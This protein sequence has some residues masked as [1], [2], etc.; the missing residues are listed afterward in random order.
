M[1]RGDGGR[2][3]Q[4]F[5]NLLSNAAKF[6]H[7]GGV[8]SVVFVV[9]NNGVRVDVRDEGRGITAEFLPYIFDRFTQA[10]R[11][12]QRNR[13]GLGLGLSIV[14]NLVQA[15]GGTVTA[16]S[17]GLDQGATFEVWLPI[18][19]PNV[20]GGLL[21]DDAEP[22][23]DAAL[24][25]VHLLV[26]DDDPEARS[27]LQLIFTDHG[28]KVR[29]AV[30]YEEALEALTEFRPD[31][32][33][34]DIGLPGKDGYQLMEEVRRRESHGEH[35]PAL[36]LTAFSQAKDTAKALASGFDVHFAKP[37]RPVQ[38][39]QALSSLVHRRPA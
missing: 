28:A 15:H 26:I 8:I 4:V 14:Q 11:A 27:I 10:E 29:F 23:V 19:G 38:L 7:K 36:A 9:E 25:D 17:D 3:Q 33:V 5:W 39:L 37:V 16:R 30:N 1:V 6:S 20:H 21:L 24:R 2:L 22:K 32:I 18:D 34:C 35:V 31:A 12:S 13:S